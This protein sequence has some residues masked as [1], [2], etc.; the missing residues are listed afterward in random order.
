M[1]R[2]VAS[3]A[4]GFWLA[5]GPL[6]GQRA[7]LSKRGWLLTIVS[8]SVESRRAKPRSTDDSVCRVVAAARRGDCNTHGHLVRAGGGPGEPGGGGRDFSCEGTAGIARAADPD[9]FAGAG[10]GAFAGS[11]RKFLQVGAGV[12]A[13]A[14]DG[15]GGGFEP[16]ATEGDGKHA[17]DCAAVAEE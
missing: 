4:S 5:S 9:Q 6:S 13:G 15:G 2:V 3:C 8:R 11:S 10:A 12:L 1:R 17:A 16:V 14:V 7:A